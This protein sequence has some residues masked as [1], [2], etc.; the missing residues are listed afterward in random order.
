[1]LLNSHRFTPP[2]LDPLPGDCPAITIT[3][4]IVVLGEKTDEG[5]LIEALG[6]PWFE[7]V[8]WIKENDVRAMLGVANADRNCSKVVVTTTSDFAPM[9]RED[10]LLSPYMPYR[11]ELRSGKELVPWLNEIA[12]NAPR[13]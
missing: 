7:I 8:R 13:T 9:V 1:M 12:G 2:R 5:T 6:I 4:A 10:P 11:L 3:A